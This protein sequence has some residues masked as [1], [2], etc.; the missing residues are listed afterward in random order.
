M[1][2][3]RA[4]G[5][6]RLIRT[7][8]PGPARC[9]ACVSIM[10]SLLLTACSSSNS[11]YNFLFGGPQGPQPG[12]PG[13][14]AGF[15]GGVATDEPR[16]ALVG[17]QILSSGGSAA[18][19][20]VAIAFALAV[21]LP[22]RAGLGGGGAC[23]AYA[24]NPKSPNNGVPEAVI[25]TPLAPQVPGADADRP[26][27]I[28]MLAR[29]MFLLQARY[30]RRPFESLIVPAEQLA[31]FGSPM[32]RALSRDLALVSGPLMADPAAAAVFSRDGQ[33]LTEGQMLTQP[34]LAAT[35]SQIRVAGVGDAYQGN[36]AR[37]IA[38]TSV[39]IGGPMTI[40]DLRGALPKLMPALI[41]PDRNDRVAFLPPPADGGLAAE[42][43][44]KALQA[45]RSDLATAQARA[46]AAAAMW[47]AGGVTPQQVVS[48]TTLPSGSLP[49]LPASTS[50]ATLDKDGDAVA[51]ALTMDNLFGTGRIFPGL[52]FLAAA[53]PSSVP[54][55]LLA[56]AQ[57]WNDHIHE[58]R[59]EA[60][61]SG[62]AGAP[63]AVAVGL[64]NALRTGQAMSVPVPDPGRANVIV[65]DRYL[66]GDSNSCQWAT[67]PRD[68]G[69]ALG[70]S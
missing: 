33:V 30:G 12:Q 29:G 52:G 22:S 36:L 27:A 37:R 66:P 6:M 61:G 31:R 19:A 68:P 64:F 8:R 51:C 44:F 40:A 46:I 35:L 50:F 67:D 17:R 39:S 15:L 70:G 47:R 62:Q 11:V 32:S 53:S 54:P 1:G 42:V 58:F 45:N 28:P 7:K 60:A 9:R 43:G 41:T 59:A 38:D 63:M 2:S 5:A 56:A 23:L 48:A 3:G 20:A 69:L 24:P 57:V 14:V 13:Y 34:D 49:P 65:C 21:T 18:D 25:F 26:A 4:G 16:A 55:P 10:L